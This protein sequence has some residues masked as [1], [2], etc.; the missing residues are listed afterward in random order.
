L[1]NSQLD[2]AQLQPKW[3]DRFRA[4]N[5]QRLPTSKS[6]ISGRMPAIF[7]ESECSQ[8][9]RTL[10]SKKPSDFLAFLVDSG[11]DWTI[12]DRSTLGSALAMTRK[13][14]LAWSSRSSP[15]HRRTWL[16]HTSHLLRW[17][18]RVGI[19][20]ESH[21]KIGPSSDHMITWWDQARSQ[22]G[23]SVLKGPIC[24]RSLS[25]APQSASWGQSRA[26]R[27]DQCKWFPGEVFRFQTEA[28][29]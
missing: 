7:S 9:P 12:I 6:H 2:F 16:A 27:T 14:S 23:E 11:F 22:T 10:A 8:I 19:R 4:Q 18:W 21:S 26:T 28:E 29:N 24:P 1:W 5:T 25:P 3:S 20:G 15:S 13:M 17:I